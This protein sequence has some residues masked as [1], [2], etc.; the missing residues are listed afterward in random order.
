MQRFWSKVRKTDKCWIWT[1]GIR[2]LSGYGQFWFQGRSVLA[3]R[4]SFALARGPL[5]DSDILLHSCDN[6]LCVNPEH[7]SIGTHDQNVRQA[8]ER[9]RTSHGEAHHNHL[10]TEDQVIE[11]RQALKQGEFQRAIAERFGIS[12]I[13][14]SNIKTEKT[15]RRVG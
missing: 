4:F 12:Q 14:V 2:N 5:P 3:H 13:T 11:I 8:V 7:L 10:L 1:A 6:R 9:N 15:W